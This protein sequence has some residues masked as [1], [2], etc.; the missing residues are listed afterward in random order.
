MNNYRE[1][2][3]TIS[4]GLKILNNLHGHGG[5]FVDGKFQAC[6]FYRPHFGPMKEIPNPS[7]RLVG[8][9]VGEVEKE[10]VK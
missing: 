7:Y 9:T 5:S 1:E 2:L 8:M 10:I 6:E 3:K 4:F